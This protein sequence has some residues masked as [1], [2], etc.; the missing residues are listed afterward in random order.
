M[1]VCVFRLCFTHLAFRQSFPVSFFLHL[2]VL[3]PWQ[4]LETFI[5]MLKSCTE[6]MMF[7]HQVFSVLL[8][9]TSTVFRVH[10][11]EC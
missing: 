9:V 7:A 8:V 3:I 11:S 2:L 1:C 6:P 5:P 4:V 10:F